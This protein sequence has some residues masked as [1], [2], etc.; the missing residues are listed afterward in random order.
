MTIAALSSG[1]EET[2]PRKIAENM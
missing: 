1:N 2:A